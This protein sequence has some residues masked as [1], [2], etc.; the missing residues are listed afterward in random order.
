MTEKPYHLMTP[1]ERTALRIAQNRA[2]NERV[3]EKGVATA[4]VKRGR[5]PPTQSTA[6]FIRATPE[7]RAELKIGSVIRKVQS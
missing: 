7:E 5:K 3:A 6:D 1:Q 2:I 4:P